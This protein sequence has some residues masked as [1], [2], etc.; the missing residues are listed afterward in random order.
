M[1]LRIG[2]AA[3]L[4]FLSSQ[5]ISQT[6]KPFDAASAFG[7]RESVSHLSLS[8]DGNTVAYVAPTTG[9]GSAVY[10]LGLAEGSKLRLAMRVT[11]NPERMR[12][13][14][15]VSNERLVCEVYGVID[16]ADVDG[17]LPFTRLLAVDADGGKLQQLSTKDSLYGN[18][19]Q[20]GGGEVIDWL[21]DGNNAVLMTRMYVPNAHTG[22]R[23][24]SSQE[25]LGVDSIDTRTLAVK[26]VEMPLRS[27]VTYL[28]DGRGVVRIL[29][30]RTQSAGNEDTGIVRYSY[31]VQ[32]S[33][34]WQSFGEYSESE[35]SGVVPYAIDHDLN[36]VYVFKKKDGRNA[37]Y[38]VALDG[39]RQEKLLYDRPDV[40]VDQLIRIGRRNR[41]V[42]V[43]YVTDARAAVYFD[44]DIQKLA[45]SLSKALPGHPP[46][47]I[48]DSSLDESKLLIFAGSDE[49]P[50]VY[51]IFDRKSHQLKTFLVT[52]DELEGVKLAVVKPV[53]YPAADG[54]MIPGYLT[55][56]PGKD[57]A[58]GLPA[59][60]LP[61]GGPDA[62]DEWGFDWLPQ[63]FASRGFAVFQPNFRGS[64]G[65]GEAWF[66]QNGFRSWPVAIGDVLSAGRWLVSQGI[67]D[68]ARLAIVGWSYGGYAALQ[69]AV[70]DPTVFKAVVAI[71]PVT[72]LEAL[73]EEH[74]YW[75]DFD[76]MRAY[77]GEGPH[78]RA[79]SPADNADKIKVPVLLFHGALDHNV[80]I[81]E[82][83]RMQA[84][85]KS[86]GGRSEL[87]TWD[88][89]DHRLEDS[90]ARSDMLRKADGFLRQAMGF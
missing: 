38:S 49:D 26:Q 57:D 20:L 51:Y 76:F 41:V 16:R 48:V 47:R 3:A 77:I 24:G 23:I 89:L 62:R 36:V 43:S 80:G 78:V 88:K 4:L 73:K 55:L 81:A 69:S 7:A 8:P 15:W 30:I 6:A 79:G 54:V 65:Y 19:F 75:S 46:M 86:A 37:L 85:L 32:G 1:T 58:R 66:Q 68:P 61:H 56:P 60:V 11:G 35:R 45:S 70:V 9:Q 72:D 2:L 39:S 82:S 59:I 12:R 5:S 10:T 21:P 25:G 84:R 28:S 87:V 90:S 74:R 42:G 71:A 27:A 29:G 17:V 34:E 13:C 44:P 53:S 14:D 52:R 22:T 67:A 50:G 33:R 18:G 63:F 40:D 31:R 83:K 64:S